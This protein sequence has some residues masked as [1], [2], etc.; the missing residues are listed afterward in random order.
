MKYLTYANINAKTSPCRYKHT[1]NLWSASGNI[2]THVTKT[3]YQQLHPILLSHL[4]TH[5]SKKNKVT[6]ISLQ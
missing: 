5:L 1:Q 6:S 4:T 2:Q 3:R